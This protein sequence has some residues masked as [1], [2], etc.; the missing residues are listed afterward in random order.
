MKNKK[1]FVLTFFLLPSFGL[2]P[3]ALKAADYVQDEVI[4]K[5]KKGISQREAND[6][7]SKVQAALTRKIDRPSEVYH[8]RLPRNITVTDA[9]KEYM[10]DANVVYAQPNY[11]YRTC[12]TPDDTNYNLL[13]GLNNTGQ[14]V[15]GTSGTS[16]ADIDAPAAWDFTTGSASVI[17]AVIDTG[18]KLT[19]TDLS[20]NIWSN[21]G[22]TAGN[23]TDDDSNGYADDVNGWDFVNDDNDPSDDCGHGTHVAG[24]IAAVGNN[25]TGVA[26]VMWTA[27]IMALKALGGTDCSGTTADLASAI[28]YAI[29]KGA[30]II[31]LS[32]G[33]DSADLTVFN[34]IDSARTSG[35][36]VVAAA[37]N[38]GSDNIG[39]DDDATPFYPASYT[40]ANIISV[41][42]TNQN[43]RLASF[44]NY[45]AASVD[46]GAPGV[47]IYSTVPK[48]SECP[49]DTSSLCSDTDYNY[50][51]GTSMAAPQV[52]GTAGLIWSA[53]PTY[54]YT[55]VK[56]AI[57]SNVTTLPQFSCKVLSGG[58]LNAYQAVSGLVS[59]TANPGSISATTVSSGEISI[60]WTNVAGETGYNIYR[61][62]CSANCSSYTLITTTASD[63]TSYS[64]TGLS[65][66]TCYNYRVRAFNAADTS[67]VSPEASATTESSAPAS[68]SSD[69]SGGGGG[70]GGCFIA[71]AVYGSPMHPHVTALRRFRDNYLLTNYPGRKF[72]ALY[73]KYS[74]PAAEVIKNSAILKTAAKALLTLLVI[75]VIHPHAS[76][77]GF[78]LSSALA[79][80]ALRSIRKRQRLT[81]GS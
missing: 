81:S 58:R 40:L 76:L 63:V 70:G 57:L 79:A 51:N 44:S 73:Y 72:T 3:S 67:S 16:D 12:L 15:N 19:H 23:S 36:L 37:G 45:G 43:D 33:M 8:V 48:V 22:E 28:T 1:I 55:E 59:G 30:N 7:N 27:K 64:D 52:S 68:S 75:F 77:V 61:K 24:T 39:D 50:S 11:I 13:W 42:A 62:L 66:G 4:I 35:I 6:A 32:L 5:F 26:G 60:S 54:T 80:A 34:A 53:N 56:N 71:T 74:P 38:G 41:T 14:T 18:I 47:N 65:S 29:N 21:T 69:S 46:L 20:A 31:N 25:A 2:T 78:I 9:I 10:K 17:I 49:Y